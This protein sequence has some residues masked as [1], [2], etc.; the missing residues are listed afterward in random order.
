MNVLSA[1][2]HTA[3]IHTA[4]GVM[5]EHSLTFTSCLQAGIPQCEPL[6][7]GPR[8][9]ERLRAAQ[10]S[11]A[12]QM[13]GQGRQQALL[14]ARKRA[15]S[16]VFCAMPD[17]EQLPQYRA[18]KSR[19]PKTKACLKKTG[20][21]QPVRAGVSQAAA[22]SSKAQRSLTLARKRREPKA[23]PAQ[24]HAADAPAFNTRA[25]TAAHRAQ[26]QDVTDSMGALTI[27]LKTFPSMQSLYILCLLFLSGR[28]PHSSPACV[29]AQMCARTELMTIAHVHR[30]H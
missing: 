21:A 26:Q 15:K 11:T 9:S 20:Q 8:R 25:Q 19:Q 10:R 2:I 5:L 7:Q 4:A 16:M 17:P 13:S 29:L 27:P 3:S 28:H 1:S 14:K 23:A 22:A 6:R 12:L 18:P 24:S 30:R